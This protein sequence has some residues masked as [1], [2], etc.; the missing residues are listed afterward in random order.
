MKLKALSDGPP[1]EL[2]IRLI[3][4]E[5][6]DRETFIASEVEEKRIPLK[7]ISIKNTASEIIRS[8]K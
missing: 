6:G 8:C 5:S 2:K 7:D 1:K 3:K 4:V